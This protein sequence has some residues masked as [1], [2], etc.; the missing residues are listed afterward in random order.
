M[1]IAALFRCLHWGY[2]GVRCRIKVWHDVL[3]GAFI[4]IT[5]STDKPLI[6][7][8]ISTVRERSLF[9]VLST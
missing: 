4:L 3:G 1:G 7:F 9:S 8:V 2:C 5:K 6:S